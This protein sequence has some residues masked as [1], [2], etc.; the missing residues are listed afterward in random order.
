MCSTEPQVVFWSRTFGRNVTLLA[1]NSQTSVCIC[2]PDARFTGPL[3]FS[4]QLCHKVILRACYSTAASRSEDS[5]C[6]CVYPCVG[7]HVCTC[8]EKP[9]ATFRCHLLV[10]A[11]QLFETVCHWL[12]TQ[13]VSQSSFCISSDRE[14]HSCHQN[15]QPQGSTHLHLYNWVP[16]LSQLAPG[17][18]PPTPLQVGA[19]ITPVYFLPLMSPKD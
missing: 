15:N 13:E 17:A 7:V 1:W 2:L 18:P 9:E 8:T 5:V 19:T 3:P 12:G 10:L 14:T 11:T 4:F 16:S 6:L